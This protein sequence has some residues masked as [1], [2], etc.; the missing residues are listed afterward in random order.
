MMICC[1]GCHIASDSHSCP[2]KSRYLDLV[3]CPAFQIL[4]R[5]AV[6]IWFCSHICNQ[7][8]AFSKQQNDFRQKSKEQGPRSFNRK[9]QSASASEKRVCKY[10]FCTFHRMWIEVVVSDPSPPALGQ[11]SSSA[12]T[13]TFLRPCPFLVLGVVDY[14]AQQE[15]SGVF[16]WD[17]RPLQGRRV[18]CHVVAA[19]VCRGTDRG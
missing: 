4:Q 9:S 2:S 17:G 14:V 6:H 18:Q 1:E 8:D 12:L 7:S 5:V 11:F 19:D 15:A 3:Q 10:R 16:L 13:L